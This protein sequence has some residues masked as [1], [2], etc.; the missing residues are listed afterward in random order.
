MSTSIISIVIVRNQPT[1]E[2]KNEKKTNSYTNNTHTILLNENEAECIVLKCISNIK[3]AFHFCGLMRSRH[4]H[5]S[6]LLLTCPL[7]V[8]YKYSF[9]GFSSCCFDISKNKCISS[10]SRLLIYTPFK[11]WFS[12]VWFLFFFNSL[13]SLIVTIYKYFSVS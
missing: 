13:R 7:C 4:S 11:I 12:H 9:A 3:Y 1:F 10:E 2:Y 8:M 6:S 5:I